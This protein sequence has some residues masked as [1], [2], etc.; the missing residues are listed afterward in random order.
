VR[1]DVVY[2]HTS[3]RSARRYVVCVCVCVCVCACVCVCVCVCH[4]YKRSSLPEPCRSYFVHVSLLREPLA[5]RYGGTQ[6]LTHV[7]RMQGRKC[8]EAY[9]VIEPVTR[10]LVTCVEHADA[11]VAQCCNECSSI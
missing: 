10:A 7:I 6:I 5:R 3:F 2:V 8:S 9:T 11:V 4:F 1:M